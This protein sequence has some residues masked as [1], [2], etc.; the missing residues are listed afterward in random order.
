V[1]VVASPD[2]VLVEDDDEEDVVVVLVDVPA[3]ELLAVPGIVLA[4]MA[5]NMPTPMTA[6]IAAPVVSRF[7]RRRAESRART[8]AWI[9]SFFSMTVSLDP[10]SK[11]SLRG[12]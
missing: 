3:D 11:P 12:S 2:E 9:V 4:L 5:P 7:S 6:V 8:R 1:V 10:P